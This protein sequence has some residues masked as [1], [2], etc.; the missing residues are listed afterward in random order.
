MKNYQSMFKRISAIFLAAV[1]A[2]GCINWNPLIA[3]GL[4]KQETVADM[5]SYSVED[6][7]GLDNDELFENYLNQIFYGKIENSLYS[8]DYGINSGK[9]DEKEKKLYSELKKNLTEIANG[10]KTSSKFSID[11]SGMGFAADANVLKASISK[12]VNML[13]VDC[14]F[15]LYWFNKTA[16]F[17]YTCSSN[18]TVIT[19]VSF[20]FAVASDYAASGANTVDN[21]KVKRALSAKKN[22]DQIIEENKDKSDYEKLNAYMKKICELNT[23]NNDAANNN[24]DAGA[25]DP[26]Q[27]VSVFDGDSSTN[28]VCEGYSKAFAYL[29]E[30]SSFKY[31]IKSYIVTGELNNGG[32]M[33]NIVTM[34]DGKNYMVDVTNCD[35]N[36]IGNPDKLFLAGLPGSVSKGYTY[37]RDENNKAVF[38]YDSNTKNMYPE[39][40]LSLSDKNYDPETA[41]PVTPAEPSASATPN[42]SGDL[43]TPECNHIFKDYEY[44][45]PVSGSAAAVL[46]YANGSKKTD[47]AT[48]KKTDNRQFI[49][50]TDITASYK[51]SDNKG[52]V[53]P[54]AGKVIVAVTMKDDMPTVNY[55]KNK[56]EKGNID[57]G[58]AKIAKAKIK[59]GRITVTATGKAK[60][61]VY[62]WVIDTGNKKVYES[63]PVNVKMAPKKMEVRSSS[64]SS[65]KIKKR[66]VVETGDKYSVY[67]AGLSPDGTVTKDCSYTYEIDPKFKD[68]IKVT[69]SASLDG[70]FIIEAIGLKNGKKTKA[71]VIFKCIENGKKVKFSIAII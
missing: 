32:H 26:W 68:Y 22:A 45:Q 49:A 27:L 24:V 18:G 62:L 15:E 2:I 63:C 53:R 35:G 66:P 39:S 8:S 40:I 30:K 57:S 61:V 13:L 44:S 51:Y 25:M 67:V 3:A 14:P 11:V 59:N 9:L 47:E 1:V 34:E 41:V 52:V 19:Q 58:A 54:A 37:T 56:I 38:T 55:D 10:E 31:A 6:N 12:I 43:V 71:S 17:T 4:E 42:P 46:I 70:N 69:S 50:Y 29:F 36:S 65:E 64:S 28:V 21:T 48:G 7:T 16:G 33:W 60:G 5:G 23:Y 20:T